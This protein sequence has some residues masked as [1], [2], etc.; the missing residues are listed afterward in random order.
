MGDGKIDSAEAILN[1]HD[2]A[3]AHGFVLNADGHCLED[4]PVW[5]MDSLPLSVWFVAHGEK[6]EN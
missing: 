1:L 3:D 4:E 2:V 6:R 5:S